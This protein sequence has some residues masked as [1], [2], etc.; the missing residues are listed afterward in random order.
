MDNI[1][2]FDF[3]ALAHDPLTLMLATGS[4][5]LLWLHAAFVKLHDRALFTQHLAAYGVPDSRLDALAW[6]LPL[7]ELALAFGLLSPWRSAA[8]LAGA[9][10]LAVY[11]A[12]MAWQLAHGRRPDCGCGSAPLPLSWALVARNAGLAGVALLAA[13]SASARPVGWTDA[14]GAAAG[15]LL[16]TLLYAGINQVL[17]QAA[18]LS[19]RFHASPRRSA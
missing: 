1:L 14:A 18:T 13:Q 16:A 11:A 7:A 10:L 19:E 17:R 2:A 4:L 3:R 12:A 5:V 15:V 9:A 8:A 6:A